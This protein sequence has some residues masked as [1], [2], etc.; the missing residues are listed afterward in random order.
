[1]CGGSLAQLVHELAQ[2]WLALLAYQSLLP[3][4]LIDK[5]LHIR[6]WRKGEQ[7]H[8]F[9]PEFASLLILQ[10]YPWRI[11]SQQEALQLHGPRTK[12]LGLPTR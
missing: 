12:A 9:L 10:D 4:N 5:Y 6:F 1:M 3:H 2:L 7:V 8:G 11:V